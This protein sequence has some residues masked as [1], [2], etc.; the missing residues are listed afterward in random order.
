MSKFISVVGAAVINDKTYIYAMVN[1]MTGKVENVINH[2]CPEMRVHDREEFRVTLNALNR[3]NNAVVVLTR[4]T[5]ESMKGLLARYHNLNA[6]TIVL[7]QDGSISFYGKSDLLMS[8][9]NGV[10]SRDYLNRAFNKEMTFV[11]MGGK[12]VFNAIDPDEMIISEY[13]IPMGQ[14]QR[15][16][17][18][19]ITIKPLRKFKNGETVSRC[20]FG[21]WHCR[22]MFLSDF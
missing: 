21:N 4:T 12:K 16:I 14:Q 11:L 20:N 5:Y 17:D 6:T 9:S 19:G 1:P 8:D 7:E 2:L 10:L 15:F 13:A 22:K 3:I 18:N